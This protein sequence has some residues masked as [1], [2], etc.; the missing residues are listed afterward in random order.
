MPNVYDGNT[1]RETYKDDYVDSDG[2]HRILF[3][4]GRALQARELT[5]LQTILQ[6]QIT[7][8]GENIFLDGASANPK[9]AGIIGTA[10]DYIKIT[11]PVGVD[12]QTLVGTY[13]RRT[14]NGASTPTTPLEFQITHA[15]PNPGDV[16]DSGYVLLYGRYVGGAADDANAAFGDVASEPVRFSAGDVLTDLYEIAGNPSRFPTMTVHAS[17]T[18]GPD[19]VTTEGAKNVGYGF[20]IS[21]QST[22]FFTQGNFVLAPAQSIVGSLFDPTP[23]LDIGFEVVQDIVTVDDTDALYDNQGVRPNLSSPGADRYRIRLIL[24]TKNSIPLDSDGSMTLDYVSFAAIRDGEIVQIKEGTEGYNQVERRMAIRHHDTHGSFIVN[25]FDI[26]YEE[27]RDVIDSAAPLID[28]VAED[29]MIAHLPTPLNSINP[30]A[31]VDGYHLEHEVPVRVEVNKPLSTTFADE[32]DIT[33][34]YNNYVQVDSDNGLFFDFVYDFE[35]NF[36]NQRQLGLMDSAGGEIVGKTR[37]KTVNRGLG[38]DDAYRVHLF[39]IQMEEGKNFRD[40]TLIAGL[41]DSATAAP[42][43]GFYPRQEDFQTFLVDPLTN[44]SLFEI[45]GG[46][47]K[48]VDDVTFSAQKYYKGTIVSGNTFSI[49]TL[50]SNDKFDEV[51]SWVI[52][53]QGSKVLRPFVDFSITGDGTN[54]ATVTILDGSEANGKEYD[55]YAQV[56]KTVPRLTTKNYQEKWMDAIRADSDENFK[57]VFNGDTLY[58]GVRLIEAYENDSASLG[59]SVHD[60]V[61]FN[62]GQTDNFY[63]PAVVDKGRISPATLALRVRVGFFEWT[64]GDYISVNSYTSHIRTEAAD[65]DNPIF[66]YADI[67]SYTT[68]IGGD[69]LPLENYLDFR[70]KLDPTNIE[71]NIERHDLP[72][73][74]K[75]V[76]ADVTYYNNRVDILALGYNGATLAPEFRINK[77]EESLEAKPPQQRQNEMPLFSITMNGNT[78]SSDDLFIERYHHKGYKMKDIEVIEGRVANLEETVSLSVLEEGAS[79]LVELDSDGNVRSKTGFFVDD[80]T[81]GMLYTSSITGPEY[82]DDANFATQT[83]HLN[84]ATIYPKSNYETATMIW[85]SD[86]DLMANGIFP[87]GNHDIIKKGDNIYLDYAEVLDSAMKQEMI[88]W[89]S[90]NRSSEEHGYYNV[91]PYN[92]FAG[93]GRVSMSP[94]SDYSQETRRIPNRILDGG[95]IERL[96]NASLVP[97]VVTSTRTSESTSTGPWTGRPIARTTTTS[98]TTTTRWQNVATRVIGAETLIQDLGDRTVATHSLPWMRQ[99]RIF[100]KAEGLRPNTRYWPFFDGVN[101]SQWVVRLTEDVYAD[102]ISTRQHLIIEDPDVSVGILEHPDAAGSATQTLITNARGELWLSYFLPNT[103]PLPDATSLVLNSEEE[104]DN[105]IT[106]QKLAA[107]QYG[108]VKDPNVYNEV[109]WKFRGGTL[110]FKLLDISEDNEDNALSK[111]RTTFTSTKDLNLV[112]KHL[113]STRVIISENYYVNG[114]I[115]SQSGGSNTSVTWFDPLAQTFLIDPQ[116]GMPGAYVTKI[117]V[118]LR[119]APTADEPQI[120]IQLQV[121]SVENGYPTSGAISDQHRVYKSAPEVRANVEAM[122]VAGGNENLGAVLSH[123]TTFEFKE[124]IYIQ[125]GTEYAICL[126][127][128]CDGYQAFVATTY[129]LILGKTNQRV[130]KQP[131]LGSLFLSQNGSTWTAKQNQ[132]LAYRIY[133]AKFKQEGEAIFGNQPYTKFTHNN[134]DAIQVKSGENKF[135]VVHLGHGLGVGDKPQISGL[136]SA[137]TY[138]GVIGSQI[139]DNTAVIDSADIASYTVSTAGAFTTTGSF[140]ALDMKSNRAFYINEVRPRFNNVLVPQ[141]QAAIQGSLLSGV[142]YSDISET[143]T[144]DPRFNIMDT[145]IS[146]TNVE[147]VYFKTPKMLASPYMEEENFGTKTSSIELKIKLTSDQESTFGGDDALAVKSAGYIS[148]VSPVIDCQRTSVDLTSFLIDNQARADQ[149]VSDAMNVPVF[150]EPETHPVLGS[151]PSKHI[152]RPIT[153][154]S[155]ANSIRVF[156]DMYKPASASFDLYYRTANDPD[157]DLYQ[158]D[159]VY[160]DPE[161]TPPNSVFALNDALMDYKEW[162]YLLGGKTGTLPDF[163]TFQLKVVMRSTNTSEI[164]VMQS[165]RAIAVV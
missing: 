50:L 40:V 69:K 27:G 55:V 96:L 2:Y 77:G 62:G 23:N 92:V 68:K 129:G 102:A 15:L 101:V 88:S 42:A 113:L 91:N 123:P 119:T 61:T 8:F 75:V 82:V 146:L 118:F 122:T 156:L 148:D 41:V 84:N 154:E 19:G 87:N 39:D 83:L 136:D 45:P 142:S 18:F 127:S 103:A 3:N 139:M 128:E 86:D 99:R 121:R 132:D 153:L 47:P 73:D 20:T 110:P 137:E 131:A 44:S 28:R 158:V 16:N 116:R 105:W 60:Q 120:P 57:V 34:D 141:T 36:R 70:S 160:A 90:D 7:T 22:K 29:Y 51:A 54:T 97:R 134:T 38:G 145:P 165:L 161:N 43:Y 74:D 112:S 66:L 104:W 125:A 11:T 52:V 157:A 162:T 115:I 14:A 25:P 67:P 124:P 1:F 79:N 159:W 138:F 114:E 89:Y 117:D 98:W 31:F 53:D 10:I 78:K 151:S 76:N 109:G 13:F 149:P 26:R 155:P 9:S 4:S 85:D 93:E 46:R 59:A 64:Q 150:Y 37:I 6:N 81:R 147:E 140:G 143:N 80:F 65:S 133:T 163:V 111:A 56:D 152:T 95:T 94:A 107:K 106:A 72:I 5:Q 17:A 33:I 164:P 30:L 144:N 21:T 135:R 126:L 108:D 35:Q 12:L 32:V 48:T 71:M 63:G 100:A 130:S 24:T 58:D 49:S